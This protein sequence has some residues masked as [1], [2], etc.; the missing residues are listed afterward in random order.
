MH[1]RFMPIGAILLAAIAF[2]QES[3]APDPDAAAPGAASAP[4]GSV[5]M[6]GPVR[7]V[8]PMAEARKQAA[9]PRVRV[10][11]AEAACESAADTV[12]VGPMQY[13]PVDEMDQRAARLLSRHAVAV[14]H[15][16]TLLKSGDY[17]RALIAFTHAAKLDQG[18]PACR[19][20]L[21]QTRLALAHYAEAAQALRRALDL[22]P[23]LLYLDLHLDRAYPS[24]SDLPRFLDALTASLESGGGTGEQYFLLGYLRFQLGD[25]EAAHKALSAARRHL[26]RD[27]RTR[28]LLALTKPPAP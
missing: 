4:P 2:G 24:P 8:R 28:E 22:Q 18:D 6:S 1:A 17:Q 11:R 13:Y 15:G 21:C 9:E 16:V 23:Q 14:R 19:I 10:V 3:P 25:F 7:A 20:H 5:R 26:T 27:E 12:D